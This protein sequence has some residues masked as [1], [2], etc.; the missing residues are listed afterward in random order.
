MNIE[1]KILLNEIRKNNREVFE[2]LFQQY[3]PPLV[4]FAEGYV[5]DQSTCEDI[6][7]SFFINFWTKS[8]SVK[9]ETSLKSYFFGSVKNLCLNKIRDLKVQDKNEVQYV[10]SLINTEDEEV[11]FDSDILKQITKAIDGLPKQMAEVFRQKYFEGKQTKE[12]ASELNVTEGTI[13]TQLHRARKALRETLKNTA[14]C[15]FIL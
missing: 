7:Q 5:Y 9:I 12:I 8:E 2:L 3:Y 13:K 6:V 4:K 10:E 15:H 1:E 11:L 14:G